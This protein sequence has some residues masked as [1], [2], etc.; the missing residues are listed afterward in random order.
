M[1]LSGGGLAW[2]EQGLGFHPQAPQTNSRLLPDTLSENCQNL[3]WELKLLA[4]T[5]LPLSIPG[6]FLCSLNHEPS[7]GKMFCFEGCW[8]PIHKV[9]MLGDQTWPS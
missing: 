1:Q 5:F 8:D 4:D 9:S 3:G 7:L 2:H 6:G